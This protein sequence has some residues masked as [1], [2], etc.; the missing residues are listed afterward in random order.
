MATD[1]KNLKISRVTSAVHAQF[2]AST[3]A[4]GSIYY[5]LVNQVIRVGDGSTAGGVPQEDPPGKII[6][7]IG[8]TIPRGYLLCNGGTIQRSQYPRLVPV[9][10]N[11]P[12]FQ[13][14]GSTTLV[15]PNLQGRFM[16]FTTDTNQV[17]KYIEAGLPNITGYTDIGGFSGK[18]SLPTGAFFQS[19]MIL[20]NNSLAIQPDSNTQIVV[21]SFDANRSNPLYGRSTTVQPSALR[22]LPLIKT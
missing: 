7:Y 20:D 21:N 6:G 17:G 15:L 3:P 5:D 1:A 14:D 11:I 9:L 10:G 16:E 19:L 13:G 22:V 18:S 4:V 2:M 12:E 8:R